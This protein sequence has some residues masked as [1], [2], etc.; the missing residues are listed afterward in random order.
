MSIKLIATDLDGTLLNEKG[1][2]SALTRKVFLR[3]QQEGIRIVLATGRDLPYF[4]QVREALHTDMFA[5][6][7]YIALNG[8]RIADLKSGQEKRT[9]GFAPENVDLFLKL[10]ADYDLE[11]LCYA[12]SGRFRYARCGFEQ[13]R[14]DYLKQH[15]LSIE[16]NVEHLLGRNMELETPHYPE[17]AGSVQ[18][19]AYLHSSLKLQQLL[20]ELRAKLP[21]QCSA[22]LV[23]PCW[24]EVVPDWL[25][26]GTALQK[27]I[28]QCGILPEQAA[29]FGD[30]ENDLGMLKSVTH[31]YAMGNAFDTVLEQISLHAPRNTEDGVARTI[32]EL[33]GYSDLLP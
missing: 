32:C 20:P 33:C 8:A 18:K 13:R 30:G 26:K 17:S 21:V 19:I 15:G 1:E 16:D 24:V 25:N 4:S 7:F 10:A 28:Q 29:A 2:V 31:G 14:L 11:A 9:Q 23:T 22:L 5:Q 12:Q 27:I 6:N 3:A